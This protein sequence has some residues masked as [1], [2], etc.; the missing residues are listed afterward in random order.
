MPT[1]ITVTFDQA[2]LNG[3][4]RRFSPAEQQRRMH[5]AMTETV[6][7]GVRRVV[8]RTPKRTGALAASIGGEV[9]SPVVGIVRSGL[10]YAQFVEEGTRP[11]LIGPR[12]K[13]ALFWA[14]AAHPVKRVYHPGTKGVGMFKTTAAEMGGLAGAIFARHLGEP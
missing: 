7:L 6:A 1:T 10:H 14:G 3:L 9:Q 13:Q 2:A 5:A 12:R 4:L 11:H 8:A